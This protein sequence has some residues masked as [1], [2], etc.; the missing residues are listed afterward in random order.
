MVLIFLKKYWKESV[1]ILLLISLSFITKD[2][3]N[4]KI[5]NKRK[6]IL[7]EQL[8][9]STKILKSKTGKQYFQNNVLKENVK[10]FKELNSEL[11][12]QQKDL[13]I[14]DKDLKSVTQIKSNTIDTF[15]L[16][17]HDTIIQH[18]TISK[19]NYED[20]YLTLDCIDSNDII[21]CTYNYRDT[22]SVFIHQKPIGKWFQFWKWGKKENKV[23]VIFG[24][25]KTKCDIKSIEIIK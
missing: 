18:D 22:A 1:I 7:I 25:P 17:K 23:D 15:L 19:Y 9:D 10:E 11:N 21:L 16:V 5:E 4:Q 24:N 6:D 20:A 8:N 14:K 13:G 12:K 2:W 3:E